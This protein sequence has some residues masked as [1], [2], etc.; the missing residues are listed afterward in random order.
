MAKYYMT[1][2]P[3]VKAVNLMTM[4]SMA[5]TLALSNLILIAVQF[6]GMLDE[7]FAMLS[8][9]Y[10]RDISSGTAY[11]LLNGGIVALAAAIMLINTI[12]LKQKRYDVYDH[13]I[14]VFGSQNLAKA[15]SVLI[16][17]DSIV[18]ISHEDGKKWLKRQFRLGRIRLSLTA[19]PKP[20]FV[21]EDM[22]H[23]EAVAAEL[24][25][26]ANYA[27]KSGAEDDVRA[28]HIIRILDRFEE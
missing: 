27:K 7:G 8:S 13:G 20:E 1:Y 3:D 21:M 24:Q 25:N 11:L 6:L 26:Y 4:T 9:Y 2:R 15:T 10:G 5:I 12:A 28:K 17:Y 18:Q 14:E 19:M 22:G 16:P 23:A